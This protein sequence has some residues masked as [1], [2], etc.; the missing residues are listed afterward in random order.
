MDKELQIVKGL[1]ETEI[2]FLEKYAFYAKQV[3]H[4]HLQHMAK[5]T[6][7]N[8]DIIL[9]EYYQHSYQVSS[10]I[11]KRKDILHRIHEEMQLK[12]SHDWEEDLIDI[13]PDTSQTIVYCKICEK[14]K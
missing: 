3:K 14:M 5:N 12:C 4:T 9:Q 11:E 8:T 2:A 7:D 10:V 1:L 13:D 6:P